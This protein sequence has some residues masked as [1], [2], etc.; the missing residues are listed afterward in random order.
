MNTNPDNLLI[1]PEELLP[2]IGSTDLVILDCRYSLADVEKGRR[3]YLQEHIPGAFFM[4]VEQDLS[5]PIIKGVTGR[6]PLPHPEV[7]TFA[8]RATGLNPSSKVVVYDQANGMAA[9]RAWWLLLWLGHENVQVLNGGFNAWKAKEYPLD[10]QWPS[11]AKG[12]FEFNVNSSLTIDKGEVASGNE[13][14]IDSRDFIRYTGETEPIDPVAGHIPGAIC[15]PFADNI[16]TNGFWKSPAFLQ[17]KFAGLDPDDEKPPVFYC[18]SGIS[19]CH[20][21]LA[22]KM[23]TGKNARLYPGSWSEWI[24]YYPAVTGPL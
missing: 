22:Y 15:M 19:A 13:K 21:I 10:N 5:S 8:L 17:D 18:G 12:K 23:A 9:S 24:N 11:P 20:N 16:D 1:T 6:H 7:L 3:D 2:I 14:V 4:D